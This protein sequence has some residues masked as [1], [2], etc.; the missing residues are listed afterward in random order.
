MWRAPRQ[1]C[2]GIWPFSRY[3]LRIEVEI[4]D[5]LIR[6]VKVSSVIALVVDGIAL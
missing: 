4:R 6:R 2:R 5:M 1:P 3:L